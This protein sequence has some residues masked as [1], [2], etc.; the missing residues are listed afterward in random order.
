M[1]RR[2]IVV[3]VAFANDLARRKN[4]TG[5]MIAEDVAVTQALVSQFVL[6][7]SNTPQFA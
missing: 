3:N 1:T 4:P 5:Q 7:G 2:S 6:A